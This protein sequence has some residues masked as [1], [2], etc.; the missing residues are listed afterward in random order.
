MRA[1]TV[2][3]SKSEVRRSPGRDRAAL[4]AGRVIER[5]AHGGRQRGYVARRAGQPGLPVDHRLAQAADVG[6]HQGSA[7]GDGLQRDD[8]ERLVVAGQHGD[9]SPVQQ[10]QQM[11]VV[12]P[13]L[14]PNGL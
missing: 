11:V 3:Q 4:S 13:A 12:G 9:V 2:C 8:P 14:E 5:G 1:A 7:G 6:G 10:F